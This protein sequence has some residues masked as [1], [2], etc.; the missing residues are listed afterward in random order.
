MQRSEME[1]RRPAPEYYRV[2]IAVLDPDRFRV[3]SDAWLHAVGRDARADLRIHIQDRLRTIDPSGG[4]GGDEFILALVGTGASSTAFYWRQAPDRNQWLSCSP[5][6]SL[7]QTLLALSRSI[8]AK[9]RFTGG[10]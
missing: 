2:A 1:L 6:Q 4:I 10:H 3:I 5:E 9:N 8:D 7:V